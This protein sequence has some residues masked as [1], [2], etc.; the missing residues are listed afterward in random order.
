MVAA[1]ARWRDEIPYLIG[2]AMGLAVLV[3]FGFPEL[4]AVRLPVNDFSYIWAGPRAV[5]DGLDPYRQADWLATVARYGTQRV[6]EGYYVYPP[7]VAL[8][9]IPLA[10]LPLAVASHVWTY[11]GMVLAALGV[12]RLLRTVAPGQPVLATLAGFALF[13]S[14]PGTAT[15][16]TGQWTFLLVAGLA[17]AVVGATG[18]VG[19][20]ML[21]ILAERGFPA[22][23]VVA[24]ASTRSVGTEVSFGDKTLKVKALDYYDFAGTDLCLMSAG[25]TVS[26]TWSPKIAAQGCLVIDNSSAWRMDRQVPLIV[27]EVNA[28]A[29]EDG[30]PKGIIANP[31]CSTAQ[32]VV[33]LKPLHDERGAITGLIGRLHKESYRITTPTATIGIRGTDHET[34]VVVPGSRLA[35]T[36]APGTYNKV[37]RGETVVSNEHGTVFVQPNQMAYAGAGAAPVLQPLNLD[38]F[39]V[40]PPPAARGPGATTTTS[41]ATSCSGPSTG[42]T[43]ATFRAWSMPVTGPVST[44]QRRSTLRGGTTTCRGSSDPAAVSGRKGWCCMELGGS[45]PVMSAPRRRSSRCSRSAVYMPT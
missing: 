7:H 21:N 4:R 36:V 15:Y 33:A 28:D 6:P 45:T 25:G 27:P 5:L 42:S 34:I 22:S 18:N 38:I 31:N 44:R 23:E 8:A 41:Y 13:A 17:L 3:L 20:E 12:R 2:L 43:V 19:R 37:N 10:A 26:K 35:A 32:L 30:I 29:L 40:P 9:L 11:G 39:V 14:Q 24:L 1:V 16:W